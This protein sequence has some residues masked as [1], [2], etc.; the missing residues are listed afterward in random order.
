MTSTAE[1]NA[2]AITVFRAV[3]MLHARFSV[4]ANAAFVVQYLSGTE[5]ARIFDA[6]ALF[7]PHRKKFEIACHLVATVSGGSRTDD[8][9]TTEAT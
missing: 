2:A 5:S 3:G 6:L 8:E 1:P 7:A 9:R 4:E